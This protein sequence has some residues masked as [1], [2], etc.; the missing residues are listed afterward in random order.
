MEFRWAQKVWGGVVV[1]ENTQNENLVRRH[2]GSREMVV[3]RIDGE[4]GGIIRAP[5]TEC[6]QSEERR[7]CEREEKREE[8]W[9]RSRSSPG[10]A[11]GSSE[12]SKPRIPLLRMSGEVLVCA[13]AAALVPAASALVDIPVRTSVAGVA[14]ERY[15][16]R[17]PALDE[18]ELVT[19]A[20]GGRSDGHCG[21]SIWQICD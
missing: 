21:R 13:G 17:R 6:E 8:N 15:H 14:L 3:G 11:D 16:C 12:A 10:R 4:E 1:L 7:V 9:V 18:G 2:W 19:G 5:D 20:V